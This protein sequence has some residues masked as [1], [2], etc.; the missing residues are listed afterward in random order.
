MAATYKWYLSGTDLI[1]KMTPDGGSANDEVTIA[2]ISGADN[3]TGGMNRPFNVV[4]KHLSDP[5]IIDE[6]RARSIIIGKSI[7]YKSQGQERQAFPAGVRDCGE[8]F[9]DL[10]AFHRDRIDHAGLF[11]LGQKQHEGDAAQDRYQHRQ[12][13]QEDGDH[14]QHGNRK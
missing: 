9:L 12:Q 10:I 5:S 2:T 3:Y 4:K 7:V 6:Y 1:Y 14:P 11:D 8:D 13:R